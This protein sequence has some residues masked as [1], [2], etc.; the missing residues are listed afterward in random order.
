MLVQCCSFSGDTSHSLMVRS[1]FDSAF[2]LFG[3]RLEPSGILPAAILRDATRS[4]RGSSSD[5]DEAVVRE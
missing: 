1:A 5:N 4:A 2:A 3:A